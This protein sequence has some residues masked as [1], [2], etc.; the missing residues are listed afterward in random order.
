MQDKTNE[1]DEKDGQQ[2]EQRLMT[3]TI[4]AL[5]STDQQPVKLA[6]VFCF[7]IWE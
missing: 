3:N 4:T 1:L 5:S 6:N 7:G 2:G